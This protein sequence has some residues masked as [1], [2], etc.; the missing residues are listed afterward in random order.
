[1]TDC[2]A[3]AARYMPEAAANVEYSIDHRPALHSVTLPLGARARQHIADAGAAMRFGGSWA[4]AVARMIDAILPPVVLLRI[5]SERAQVAGLTAYLRFQ[6]EPSG[7]ALSALLL[8]T[9][10][11]VTQPARLTAVAAALGCP[12]ARGIGLRGGLDGS[13]KLAV[14]FKV[15]RDLA[16]FAAGAVERLMIDCGWPPD[17][18]QAIQAD[19]RAVHVG[20]SVGVIGIDLD[21]TGA[22]SALKCDPANVP[23]ERVQAFLRLKNAPLERIR[24]FESMSRAMRARSLSYLGIKYTPEGFAGWRLYF[25]SRPDAHRSTAQPALF[26]DS[27]GTAALRMPHY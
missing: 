14:Y 3:L 10:G 2:A 24:A 1:M 27:P 5:D 13:N 26:V 11:V 6:Q 18:A 15:E 9:C 23:L 22:I 19:L 8:R 12:G 16:S 20:G 17:C 7:D 25:S 21:D 4:V